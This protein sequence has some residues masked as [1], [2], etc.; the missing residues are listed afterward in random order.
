MENNGTIRNMTKTL[1]K[2]LYKVLY[3]RMYKNFITQITH[4]DIS[5]GALTRL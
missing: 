4:L 5:I 2:F 3:K 1:Y